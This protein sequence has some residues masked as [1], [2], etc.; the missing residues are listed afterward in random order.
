M[1]L[2]Q[3]GQRDL[4]SLVF[5]FQCEPVTREETGHWSASSNTLI[6]TTGYGC[7][8]G[9]LLLP[10]SVHHLRATSRTQ[11]SSVRSGRLSP[12]DPPFSPVGVKTWC[13]IKPWCPIVSNQ[14]FV[15][16]S[17]C[18]YSPSPDFLYIFLGGRLSKIG[19]LVRTVG[20][21]NGHSAAPSR[22][23][24]EARDV[25]GQTASIWA[26]NKSAGHRVARPFT[27]PFS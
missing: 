14:S 13:P 11:T 26:R 3:L 5:D 25:G 6:I 19:V 2:A 18:F 9:R 10:G 12:L 4:P 8:P 20:S 22:Q 7:F 15:F 21:S 16:C 1:L 24:V 27:C 23:E 17:C